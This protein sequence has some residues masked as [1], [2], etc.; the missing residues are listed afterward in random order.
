MI[1]KQI[2]SNKFFNL[3][4]L[5]LTEADFNFKVLGTRAIQHAEDINE[6]VP[7]QYGSH[8]AKSAIDQALH[9]RLTYDIM[10]QL[11]KSEIL[12]SNDTKS[13]YDRILHFIAALA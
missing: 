8:K 1:K 5:V 4:S 7:E 11:R 10:R 13:C 9:K 12:C 2:D 3:R 6:L